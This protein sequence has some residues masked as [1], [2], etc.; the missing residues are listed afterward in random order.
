MIMPYLLV[1]LKEEKFPTQN[2]FLGSIFT[3]NK[4]NQPFALVIKL[5]NAA[6]AD[7]TDGMSWQSNI[8]DDMVLFWRMCTGLWRARNCSNIMSLTKETTLKGNIERLSCMTHLI[9]MSR[10]LRSASQGS[11]Q[12]SRS[13]HAKGC[14]PILP[15]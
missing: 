6:E 5:N 2:S 12:S 15:S 8:C 3:G 1:L 13:M 9:D 14:P 10:F 4:M 7:D 11:L